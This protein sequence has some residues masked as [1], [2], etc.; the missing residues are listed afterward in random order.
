MRTSILSIMGLSIGMLW[1]QTPFYE[2]LKP[3]LPSPS[4]QT[5]T[6]TPMTLPSVPPPYSRTGKWLHFPEAG[7]S[8]GSS[9]KWPQ[10]LATKPVFDSTVVPQGKKIYEPHQWYALTEEDQAW[11]WKHVDT[12]RIMLQLRAVSDIEQPALQQLFANYGITNQLGKSMFPEQMVFFEYAFPLGTA[13]AMKAFIQ[14]CKKLP[15]VLVAEPSSNLQSGACVP[16]DPIWQ[17]VNEYWGAWV[18]G[19]DSA[20]C[21]INQPTKQRIAILDNAVDWYHQDL[22]ETVWYGYDFANNDNDPTPDILSATH[23]THVTGISSAEINNGMGLS[24]ISPDTVYFAKVGLANGSLSN[25]A[26]TNAILTIVNRP[27]IR[28]YNMS[29]G[30]FAPTSSIES[31]IQQAWNAGKL[32]I[33]AAG[34]DDTQSPTYPANYQNVL[35]VSAVGVNSNGFLVPT[36]YTNYGNWIDISAPGGDVNTPFAIWSSIPGNA[37]APKE[38][39][40]M[41]APYVTGVAGL[42]FAINPFLTAQQA[43]DILIQQSVDYGST[44]FDI[45]YGHGIVNAYESIF[46]ACSLLTPTASAA[47]PQICAGGYVTLTTASN[48]NALYQWY[49]NGQMIPG[50]QQPSV[51]AT[52]QGTY[53][54]YVQSLGGCYGYSN[55]VSLSIQPLAQAEFTYSI[56][57]NTVSFF[58]N[59]THTT[60]YAWN[61]GDGNTSNQANPVHTYAQPGIYQVSLTASN[62]CGPHTA[63][64]SFPIGNLDLDPQDFPARFNVY[65]NPTDGPIHLKCEIPMASSLDIRLTNVLGALLY[66]EN[67]ELVSGELLVNIPDQSLPTG[68][69]FITLKTAYGQWVE[70]IQVQR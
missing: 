52:Q 7:S 62:V 21:Y 42:I 55:P 40:S 54:V 2:A 49:L 37:Y 61:F 13:A 3:S 4:A 32:P 66:E 36:W 68:T 33:A 38:G 1:A 65:P 69:Y 25:T 5:R 46:A 51:V 63:T 17:V 26:I 59:A 22:L 34:N 41:A 23:G 15:F 24:G 14:E 12:T 18:V 20:Y 70:K 45:F 16:N 67:R 56:S 43:R 11:Y 60:G 6:V 44:G 35:A 47:S 10:H 28:A 19:A 31:A 57:G 30:A 29:F 58:Q 39:T 48:P 50:A 64:K 27:L 53:Q 9:R 8:K